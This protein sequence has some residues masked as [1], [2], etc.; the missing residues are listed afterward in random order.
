MFHPDYEVFSAG[1]T[2]GIMISLVDL[3]CGV[4]RMQPPRSPEVRMFF[5]SSNKHE[6]AD[7][8]A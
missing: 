6:L 3:T 5:T 2:E 7:K 1:G 8:E 4:S